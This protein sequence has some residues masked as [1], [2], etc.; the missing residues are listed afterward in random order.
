MSN[1]ILVEFDK[2]KLQEKC[3]IIR[4]HSNDW[5]DKCKRKDAELINCLIN[6]K[7]SDYRDDNFKIKEQDNDDKKAEIERLKSLIEHYKAL[8]DKSGTRIKRVRKWKLNIFGMVMNILANKK[9]QKENMN[10]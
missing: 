3:K 9:L 6:G 4:M 1:K 8:S 5:C 10:Q 7:L 2:D